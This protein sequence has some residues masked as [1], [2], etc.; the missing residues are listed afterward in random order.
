MLTVDGCHRLQVRQLQ[1]RVR[2]GLHPHH[3]C[4]RL[5]GTAQRRWIG[6]VD[7]RDLVAGAAATH[8]LEQP[9]AAAIEVVGR[10]DVRAGVE[11]LQHRRHRGQTG[12]ERIAAC[13]PFEHGNAAL[14]GFAGRVLRARVLVAGVHARALLPVGRGGVDRRYHGTGGRIRLLPAVNH[15]VLKAR[16]RSV[17]L[18]ASSCEGG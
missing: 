12:G 4:L 17:S 6:Q 15:L 8:A 2:R 1:Q 10:N 7:K 3:A 9:E 14:K 18:T 13:A 5:D 16:F 11:Q